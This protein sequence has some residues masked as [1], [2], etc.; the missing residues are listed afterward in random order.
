MLN[1]SIHVPREGHDGRYTEVVSKRAIS[2]HVPREGHDSAACRRRWRQ[3]PFQSTC[4]ARGTTPA[5]LPTCTSRTNFNPR[6]PRGARLRQR[7]ASA[8]SGDFNPRAPRGA[9]PSWSCRSR[10]RML[11][12]NPRAPRGARHPL[13]SPTPTTFR[14][15]IHVPRE[16]HDYA[17]EV[18]RI[19]EG[20][21]QSTCPARGTT[22]HRCRLRSAPAHFNPRAPRGAR[23]G[24]TLS[25]TLSFKFQSTCPARGTTYHSRK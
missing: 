13:F 22:R 12:F 15:S 2:I 25:F 1:I 24:K 8:S 4:P 23:P 19:Y 9:R 11:Y 18:Y 17:S 7:R 21:F 16:G 3:T 10:R 5:A 6:A 14:I 20:V